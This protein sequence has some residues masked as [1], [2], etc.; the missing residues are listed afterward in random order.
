MNKI[1]YWTI[2]FLVVTSVSAHALE[3]SVTPFYWLPDLDA[4]LKIKRNKIG[5]TVDFVDDLGMDDD[6]GVQGGM[7]DLKF[8]RS[9]HFY[10]S[11]WSVGYDE[12]DHELTGTISYNG[13]V[14]PSGT[15]VTSSLDLD[16]FEGGYAFDL[17]DFETFRLGFL[18]NVN[19]YAVDSKI[20][21]LSPSYIENDDKMDLVFPL[22]GVRSRMGFWG[23]RIQLSGRFAGL[24]WHGSG[25]WDGSAEISYH[26][27]NNLSVAGGYRAIHLDASQDDDVVNIKLDGLI[28]S[29]TYRF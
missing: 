26:P 10:L 8:G 20:N 29:L 21:T 9:N 17:L 15:S 12:K 2:C 3:V 14:Y 1:L 4:E 28:A 23:N 6:E 27:Y 16:T 24:W 18:L 7:V 13:I 22:L 25:W 5:N 19:W 11:Y